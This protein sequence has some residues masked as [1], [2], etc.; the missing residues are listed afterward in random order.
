M[1]G[2]E[3][4]PSDPRQRAAWRAERIQ[5]ARRLHPDVGGEA[6]QYLAALAAV[7]H[8]FGSARPQTRSGP[9]VGLQRGVRRQMRRS[10]TGLR[11]LRARLPR[12]VPGAKRYIDL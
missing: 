2:P 5:V 9:W 7:D 12:K 4:G 10:R 3:R 6:A 1:S 8:R 11:E